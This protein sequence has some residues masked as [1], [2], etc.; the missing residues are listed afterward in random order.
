MAATVPPITPA[1][2]T[3]VVLKRF[4]EATLIGLGADRLG[5]L[6]HRGESLVLAYHNV[7][8][9]SV[10]AGDRSLHIPAGRFEAHIDALVRAC[11]V[12]PLAAVLSGDGAEAR[13]NK[14]P[15]VA[16]TFDDAYVGALTHGLD[17][18]VRYGLPATV[19]VAPARLGGSFWWDDLSGPSGLHDAVRTA[20]LDACAGDDGRV[21]AWAAQVR[22][23]TYP[24][25]PECRA[26]TVEQ[27]QVAA[28][29]HSKLTLASHTWS[30]PN[31]SALSV[32]ALDTELR[33]PL[34][35][36]R[37]R[38][39][40]VPAWI[41]YPY[42]L[43]SPMVWERAQVAGYAAGFMIS[44]GWCRAEHQDAVAFGRPR[45]NIP[46]GLSPAG[47]RLRLGRP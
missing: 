27:L 2:D 35:W 15:T 42:G 20:A 34:D 4:A 29:R 12:V 39:Q 22:L 8:P 44:G 45:L 10:A 47:F 17:V 13:S 36:L 14:R 30:H 23:P 24:A 21:R 16:I 40:G 1:R 25:P 33:Q 41:A 5:L 7:V 3:A 31:L 11:D 28:A 19:F 9:N 37:E 6:R 38:F 18:L 43:A 26:A 32:D 46:A